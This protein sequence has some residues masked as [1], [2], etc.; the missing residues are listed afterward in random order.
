M[1]RIKELQTKLKK[2]EAFLITKP[3]NIFYLTGFEGISKN[4][5][6]SL[7]FVTKN[8]A[9]HI[10]P[11]M[12]ANSENNKIL[13]AHG[14]E[15]KIA[16]KRFIDIVIEFSSDG[17]EV[18][19]FEN[20]DLKYFE[21]NKIAKRLNN[22]KL[23]P[24]KNLVESLRVSKSVEEIELIKHAQNITE[25]TLAEGIKLLE[26]GGYKKYSEIQ[27]AEVLRRISFK[28]GGEGLGFD[29]IVASGVGSA[30]PHYSPARKCLKE[31]ENLLIDIGIKYKGYSGDLSRTFFV[32]KPA[33]E[34]KRYYDIVKDCNFFVLESIKAGA[35]LS[36]IRKLVDN[37]FKKYKVLN[38]FTHSIGH[39]I[40]L[41]I[42]EEP[43]VRKN[44]KAKLKTGNVFTVEPGLYFEDKYGIRIEDMVMIKDNG[45]ELLNS[46]RF[47]DLYLIS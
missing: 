34:F 13:S 20:S 24:V 6:E 37:H 7:L 25:N 8:K 17:L 40:G 10:L 9:V 44:G 27:F 18:L 23:V 35:E 47:K 30:Q 4:E 42:H 15:L 39:G 2:H 41:E 45:F 36:M 19:K 33:S 26:N 22:I 11:S 5:R 31:N 43:F 16:K 21:Y 1:Q 3:V 12:Y 29:T 38:K 14:I 28:L 32:G 46:S